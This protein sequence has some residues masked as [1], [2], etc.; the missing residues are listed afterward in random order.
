[1]NDSRIFIRAIVAILSDSVEFVIANNDIVISTG[2]TIASAI[3]AAYW[4][5]C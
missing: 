5:E 2:D 3:N 4:S 1:M